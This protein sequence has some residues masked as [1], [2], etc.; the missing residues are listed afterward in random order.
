MK[1]Y[2]IIESYQDYKGADATNW[3]VEKSLEKAKERLVGI[4]EQQFHYIREDFEDE[5][6]EDDGETLNEEK[7]ESLWQEWV[8]EH[9]EEGNYEKGYSYKWEYDDGDCAYKFYIDEV[10]MPK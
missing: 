7:L 9:L 6:I 10:A 3:G 5:A 2:G 1:L 8:E 4:I